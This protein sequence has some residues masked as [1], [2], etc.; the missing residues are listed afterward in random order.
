MKLYDVEDYEYRE[1]LRGLCLLNKPIPFYNKF[2]NHISIGDIITM[3]EKAYMDMI[4]VFALNKKYITNGQDID[5]GLLDIL[6]VNADRDV[7]FGSIFSA[8]KLLMNLKNNPELVPI[9]NDDGYE[10]IE[11]VLD[12]LLFID[13]EKYEELRKI[14]LFINHIKDLEFKV[15]SKKKMINDSDKKRFEKLFKGREKSK[16]K[17]DKKNTILNFYNCVVHMQNPVDYDSISKWS[18][19]RL[20]NTFNNLRIREDYDFN[21]NLYSSGMVELKKAT[22]PIYFNEITKQ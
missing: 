10:H 2:I 7:I 5:I 18:I 17:E 16:Q 9:K 8:L 14:I 1:Y 22:I 19:Y 12:G 4:S 13:S 15:E 11:I 20:Y 21:R 3:G 6:F